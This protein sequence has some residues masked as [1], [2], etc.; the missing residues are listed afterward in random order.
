[1]T[2]HVKQAWE[3]VVSPVLWTLWLARNKYIFSGIELSLEISLLLVQL[4]SFQWCLAAE[5]IK[6]ELES[7]C[8]VNPEGCILLSNK[9]K[10]REIFLGWNTSLVGF[11]DG[12][13]KES[14]DGTTRSG[15][16]GIKLNNKDEILF[17]FSG[18]FKA[19]LPVEAELKAIIFLANAAM[20]Q[21]DPPNKAV[22]CTDCALAVHNLSKLRAGKDYFFQK[23]RRRNVQS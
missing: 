8:K 20:N 1:M 14:E 7:L 2:A 9:Y 23:K 13:F 22:I 11:S 3:V 17:I 15:M 12:S 4:R 18:K 16:R 21:L 19:S 6:S 10:R 5:L